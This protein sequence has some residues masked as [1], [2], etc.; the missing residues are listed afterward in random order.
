MNILS[1]EKGYV[2]PLLVVLILI[3]SVYTGYRF[4]MP[5]YRYSALKSDAKQMA[6]VSLGRADKLKEMILEKAEELKVPVT[7][8]DIFVEKRTKS[9]YVRLSWSEDVD[10]MGVY[11]KKLHF[12]IEFDE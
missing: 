5:Y 7:E 2:K 3:A 9:V 1:K 12:N 4:G 10:I 8:E 6:R 11:G